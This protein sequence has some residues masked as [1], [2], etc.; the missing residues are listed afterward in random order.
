MPTPVAIK[1]IYSMN[2]INV[3][4]YGGWKRIVQIT[5]IVLMVGIWMSTFMVVWH[6]IEKAGS[7]KRRMKVGAFCIGIALA[8]YLVFCLVQL[9][10]V[11]YWPT[12]TGA[13]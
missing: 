7:L 4:M 2:M 8:A 3:S 1:I 9:A 10:A 6:K 11:G 5:A 13:V 12:L